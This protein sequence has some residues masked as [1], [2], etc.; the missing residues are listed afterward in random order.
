M[1]TNQEEAFVHA[2]IVPDK[3]ERY[4]Q[5]LASPRRREKVLRL[6]YHSLDLIPA[7]TT[8]IANRDHGIEPVEKLLRSKGAGSMCYLI[9]PERELDQKEMALREALET[10]ITQDGVAIVCCLPGRLAYYKA[11]LSQYVLEHL[12]SEAS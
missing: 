5:I 12:P 2:F 9:S 3:R 1:D 8:S 4:L 6:L 10:L 11:E 7:R